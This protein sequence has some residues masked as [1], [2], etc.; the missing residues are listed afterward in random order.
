MKKQFYSIFF[1]FLFTAVSKAQ[2]VSVDKTRI[3]AGRLKPDSNFVNYLIETGSVY[4]KSITKNDSAEVFLA[5]AITVA[6]KI[7]YIKGLSAARY[8]QAQNYFQKGKL[9]PSLN[10]LLKNEVLA[11]ESGDSI[12]L[13]NTLRIVTTIYMKIGD[14]NMAAATLSRRQLILDNNG[15]KGLKD[16]SYYRLS[17]YN[18]LAVYYSSK[19]INKPDSVR[20]FYG[21]IYGLGRNT[22]Y[23]N[24]WAQLGAGGLGGYFSMKGKYDS[25]AFYYTIAMATSI[26]GKRFDNYYDFVLALANTYQKAG[27]KDS[28][29]LYAYKVYD[30]ASKYSYL[31]LVASSSGLLATL[32]NERHKYDSAVKYMTFERL[33]KDSIAGQETL[34]S[35]QVLTS[36]QQFKQLEKQR[37]KDAAIR[38]YKSAIKNYFFIGGL[39]LLLAIIGF[40]YR[41]NKQRAKSKKEIETAY[42]QLKSTQAQLVQSEKMASLGELTAGIAHEIQNPLN[43][44]NNFSEVNKELLIDMKEEIEKGNMEEVKSIAG[45]VI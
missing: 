22:S 13:F 12:A 28:A 37:E 45:D 18:S 30:G 36:E 41:V 25:A 17:Q 38:E 23:A 4:S 6:E 9:S 10:L 44:V 39:L 5:E 34:K 21:K 40:M 26:D 31:S 29:F 32:Y 1:L 19:K 20:F 42:H 11:I 3:E 7:G 15:I 14:M 27:Q 43:F 35:I 8:D 33:F 2:E 16:T 24:L